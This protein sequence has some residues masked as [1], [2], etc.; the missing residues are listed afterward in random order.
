[1]QLQQLTRQVVFCLMTIGGVANVELAMAQPLTDSQGYVDGIAAVV[2]QDVITL[3]Q[4]NAEVAEVTKNLRAQKFQFPT[5]KS[6]S[7]RFCNG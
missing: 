5:R 3:R 4:V 1:M 7:V 6:Y 2:N